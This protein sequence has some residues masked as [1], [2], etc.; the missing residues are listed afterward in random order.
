MSQWGD[1]LNVQAPGCWYQYTKIFT[2][3][4]PIQTSS[5]QYIS[6][7]LAALA[8]IQCICSAKHWTTFFSTPYPICRSDILTQSI[9]GTTAHKH[10]HNTG[11]ATISSN[12]TKRFPGTAPQSPKEVLCAWEEQQLPAW[13]QA[14][15]Q[16]LQ[17][18]FGV[19]N[20]I[21]FDINQD[22]KKS[23]LRNSN[24]LV[25]VQVFSFTKL[26][27]CTILTIKIFNWRRKNRM[28]NITC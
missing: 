24:N 26:S 4:V 23:Y 25:E 20:D 28:E 19:T 12:V 8:A 9:I 15:F 1:I 10:R 16:L 21:E 11:L 18:L 5:C 22:D 2:H 14:C 17:N 7:C 3:V 13:C 27:N 6:L